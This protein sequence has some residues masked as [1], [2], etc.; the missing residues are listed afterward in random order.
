MV[1]PRLIATGPAQQRGIV[2]VVALI[3]L[4]VMALVGLGMMRQ[5]TSGVSI[6]G[7]VSMR[8]AALAGADFGTDQAVYCLQQQFLPANGNGVNLNNNYAGCGYYATWGAYTDGDPIALFA[9]PLYAHVDLATDGIQNQAS[10]IIQ[11]LCASTGPSDAIGQQCSVNDQGCRQQHEGRLSR[12]L[13]IGRQRQRA[14]AALSHFGPGLGPEG[15][16]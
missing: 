16:D 1:Q 3:V 10:Y 13:R 4:V 7:N 5:T 9:N 6:A 15:H 2:L 14:T 8:Q 11:R 12:Q